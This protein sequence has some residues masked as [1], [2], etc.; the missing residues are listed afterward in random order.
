MAVAGYLVEIL[1]GALG[2]I[3]TNRAVSAIGEGPRWNYTAVMNIGFLVVA[4]VLIVRFLRTGGPAM[5]QMMNAPESALPMDHG[6]NS[7]AG[8][9]HHAMGR[10]HG[11]S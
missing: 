7:M 3:P 2:I 8:M 10:D 6:G 4:A 1:F 5:L 9:D 11:A